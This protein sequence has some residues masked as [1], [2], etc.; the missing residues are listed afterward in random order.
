MPTLDKRTGRRHTE[1]MTRYGV[2]RTEPAA[3]RIACLFV[4]GL[5]GE[6]GEAILRGLS[7]IAGPAESSHSDPCVLVLRPELRARLYGGVLGWVRTVRSYL[8]GR[9]LRASLVVGFDAHRLEAL[10]RSAPMTRIFASVEDEKLAV[11]GLRLTRLPMSDEERSLAHERNVRTLRELAST[12][13]PG[14]SRARGHARA[15]LEGAPQLGLGFAE[16]VLRRSA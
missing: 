10:A 3:G 9:H 14:L 1:R 15:L 16:P 6:G 5:S 7:V 13:H 2:P 4:P 12:T 8:S 11:A